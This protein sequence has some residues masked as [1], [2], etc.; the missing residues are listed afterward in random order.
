VR[1]VRVFRTCMSASPSP[2]KDSRPNSKH[3]LTALKKSTKSLG[4]RVI[5]R[6]TTPGKAL[7]QWRRE[8]IGDLGGP[9]AVSTQQLAFI[10]LAVRTKLLLDSI[11]A[12]LLKQPSLVNARR[13]AVLPVVLQ[14]QQLA[15]ALARFLTQLSPDRR[16]KKVTGAVP[17]S[18]APVSASEK[19]A[20]R[21]LTLGEEDF[22]K[23]IDALVPRTVEP[24]VSPEAQNVPAGDSQTVIRQDATTK[25][26]DPAQEGVNLSDWTMRATALLARI[27]EHAEPPELARHLAATLAAQMLPGKLFETATDLGGSVFL[28]FLSRLSPIGS[29]DVIRPPDEWPA[30]DEAAAAQLDPLLEALRLRLALGKLLTEPPVW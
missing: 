20:E 3:G 29:P 11:D 22:I 28:G 1:V 21:L 5:D 9:E 26:H 8:L 4:G 18:P 7:A 30:I 23:A 16:T 27:N 17:A 6:R 10:E 13:R 25:N 15:D 14:R 24:P 2:G 19:L 12:W